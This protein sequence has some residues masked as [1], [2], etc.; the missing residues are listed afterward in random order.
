METPCCGRLPIGEEVSYPR[1]WFW[2]KCAVLCAG[3]WGCA[4]KLWRNLCSP[5]SKGCWG[6]FDLCYLWEYFSAAGSTILLLL[7]YFI[8]SSAFERD[9]LNLWE[10]GFKVIGCGGRGAVVDICYREP[11]SGAWYKSDALWTLS[12]YVHCRCWSWITRP[13]ISLFFWS[14]SW[15]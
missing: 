2:C 9:G 12:W 7:W 1:I 5:K 4:L 8:D 15:S 3:A 14:R 6:T 11:A 10:F 13:I